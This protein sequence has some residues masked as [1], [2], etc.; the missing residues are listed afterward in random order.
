MGIL[1]DIKNFVTGGSAEVSIKLV[2]EIVEEDGKLEATLIITAKEETVIGKNVYALVEA[3]EESAN[4]KTIYESRIELET[5]VQI[6][7]GESRSWSV[8]IEIP[9]T[10]PSTHFG[11]HSK[12]DWKLTGGIELSGINPDAEVRFVVNRVNVFEE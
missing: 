2:N 10:A 7:A 8:A 9:D 6:S 11:K 1:K 3:I 4:K 12:L 5:S